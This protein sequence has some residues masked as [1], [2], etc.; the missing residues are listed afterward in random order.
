MPELHTVSPDFDWNYRNLL[1]AA[2]EANCTLQSL[3]FTLSQDVPRAL[4]IS[5]ATPPATTACRP[6]PDPPAAWCCGLRCC[7]VSTE[8]VD[9]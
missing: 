5:I 2:F 6:A 3:D 8:H 1:P 9:R 4:N 7:S